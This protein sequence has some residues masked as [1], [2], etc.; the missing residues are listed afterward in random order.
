VTGPL[1]ALL[2]LAV[3]SA[4]EGRLEDLRREI[5]ALDERAARAGGR[6][7]SLAGEVQRLDRLAELR[8]R[9]MELLA[10]RMEAV[11]IRV[12]KSSDRMTQVEREMER[13][14]P[15]LFAL[16]DSFGRVGRVGYVGALLV[17]PDR[18]HFPTAVRQAGYLAARYGQTLDAAQGRLE[19]LQ[20]IQGQLETSRLEVQRLQ[21]EAEDAQRELQRARSAKGELLERVRQEREE[22]ET[23]RAELEAAARELQAL[24]SGL[25]GVAEVPVVPIR[26]YRG[27]LGWPVEGTVTQDFGR[28][29]GTRHEIPYPGMDIWSPVGTPIRAVSAGSDVFADWFQGYGKTICL[30]HGEGYITVYAHVSEILVRKG[31]GV[32]R[33]QVI[34]LVGDTGSLKGPGLYFQISKDGKPQDPRDWLVPGGPRKPGKGAPT[35]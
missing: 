5:Q 32:G 34:G 4:E 23:L 29:R 9:E 20:G 30:D 35:S 2:L 8:R 7:E 22:A 33:D 1:L 18:P 12:S 6:E 14:R 17:R 21:A 10:L 16:R 3:P 11:E 24:V 15:A 31:Q 26:L 27:E 25:P 28:V 13:W 19:E